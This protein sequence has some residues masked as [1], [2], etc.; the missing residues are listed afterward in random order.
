[1]THIAAD[2]KRLSVLRMRAYRMA[3]SG[4]SEI[5]ADKRGAGRSA[6]SVATGATANLEPVFV[7]MARDSAVRVKGRGMSPAVKHSSAAEEILGLGMANLTNT[8]DRGRC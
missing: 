6:L 7:Q 3:C 5:G 8:F 2:V 4:D 1:M